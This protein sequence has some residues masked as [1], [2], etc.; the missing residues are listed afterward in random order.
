M[1]QS[2]FLRLAA[3]LS[4]SLYAVS[5]LAADAGTGWYGGGGVGVSRVKD[6]AAGN[7]YVINRDARDTGYK[8]FGGYRFTPHVGLEGSYLDLGKENFNWRYNA[9]ESGV[10]TIAA[11]AFSLAAVGRLPVGSGF[12]L[13]GKLGV[14]NLQAKYRENWSQLGYSGTIS[15]NHSKTVATYGVGA[16]YAIDQNLSMRA[17]YEAFDKAK[18]NGVGIKTNLLSVGLEYRF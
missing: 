8:I 5:S 7:G 11:R 4:L 10:G 15:Q 9:N 13:L 2:N 12:S 17:E 16:E 1:K 6:D 3:V 14:A 18:A